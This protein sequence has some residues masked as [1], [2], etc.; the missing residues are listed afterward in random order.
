M[1]FG[2]FRR[3]LLKPKYKI[4]QSSLCG[5]ALKNHTWL[6]IFAVYPAYPAACDHAY[7]VPALSLMRMAKAP[8]LNRS[9][10]AP[11]YNIGLLSI[12]QPRELSRCPNGNFQLEDGI[13]GYFWARSLNIFLS[14]FQ[15][16]YSIF[17]LSVR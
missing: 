16:S 9:K 17:P 5:S 10:A 14:N 12:V 4:T 13:I 6:L 1:V 11:Y 15:A 3:N 2:K 7:P 8:G